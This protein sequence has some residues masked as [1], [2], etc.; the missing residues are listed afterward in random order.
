MPEGATTN[1]TSCRKKMWKPFLF[2]TDEQLRLASG[3]ICAHRGERM[4]VR[5]VNTTLMS[6]S[7]ANDV[8][9]PVHRYKPVTDPPRPTRQPASPRRSSF[10]GGDLVVETESVKVAALPWR[11]R[12]CFFFVSRYWYS[13][14][15]SPWP[16]PRKPSHRLLG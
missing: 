1:G 4:R 15:P 14:R 5:Y 12:G 6:T 11:T 16:V 3:A 2:V 8:Y 13:S 9:A 10:F 7:I